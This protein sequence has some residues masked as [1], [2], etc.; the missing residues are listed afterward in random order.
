MTI[1]RAFIQEHGNG[2]LRHE[3]KLV[4]EEL[5]HRGIPIEF[6]TEKRIRRRQLPLDL[7]SLVVGDMP[8]IV[9]AL[10]QLSIPEPAPND[11]PTS[12]NEFLYRR[13]WRSNY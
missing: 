13:I 9:G 7:E 2:K 1:S 4:V 12:L 6:Y 10:Q 11:Y 5:K 3:E 8:C